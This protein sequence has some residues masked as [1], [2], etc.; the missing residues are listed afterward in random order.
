MYKENKIFKIKNLNFESFKKTLVIG[1][2]GSNHNHNF[3]K[4]IKLINEAKKAGC[5]AVKF[6]L[7][8][9]DTI[10]QKKYP[11]WKILSKLELKETWLKKL[12]NYTHK[13]NMLFSV[14]PFDLESV[15]VLKKINIDFFKIASTELEDFELIKEVASSRKPI[16]LSTGAA[17]L[18]EI[19]EAIEIL[20]KKKSNL[21]LLH[22]V[23]I[24]PPRIDQMNLNMINSLNQAFHLPIGFSDHSTSFTLPIVAV[25]L[26]ACIIE[27]HITLDKKSKGPDH[28]F[29]LEPNEL[30]I[31]VKGIREIEKSMGSKIK[32]PVVNVE[33]KG[34]ARRIVSLKNMKKEELVE[35]KNLIIKRAKISGIHPRDFEKIL[36]LSVKKN[37][38]ADDVLKWSDFK[39]SE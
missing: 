1:E 31:M 15:R 34:L 16:I 27:K 33:K 24:Y 36:G 23:S 13:K 12:K 29:S 26:G 10:I 37:I 7:F 30:K 6:Q 38:K 21:A 11:G 39:S 4:T 22:T 32:Q 35:R 5:D 20:R 28:H 14:S 17:R 2:I 18:T 3:S 8:K 19:S 9:A 25:S